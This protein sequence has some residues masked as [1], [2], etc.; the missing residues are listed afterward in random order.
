V[1]ALRLAGASFCTR[2]GPRCRRPGVRLRI[3][4]ARAAAVTGSLTRRGQRGRARRFGRVDLG[5]VPAGPRTLRF[6]R[7]A[8]G[9][10]LTAGRYTLR[11]RI[12]AAAPRM[13]RFR[14]RG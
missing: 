4:L 12:G 13:L 3:D 8:T 9:R 2:R 14:I 6:S 10:R 11:L 5:T 7:T 1:R